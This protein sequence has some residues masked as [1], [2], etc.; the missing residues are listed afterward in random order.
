[1]DLQKLQEGEKTIRP[2]GLTS[3]LRI[4]KPT[5]NQ[6]QFSM[7]TDFRKAITAALLFLTIGLFTNGQAIFGTII[8]K[9][10]NKTIPNA[11]VY[12]N[13]TLIGT[14]SD[15]DGEFSLKLTGRISIPLTVS[16]LGYKTA[17]I[18][19]DNTNESLSIYLTPNPI[20]LG[21]V[22]VLSESLVKQRRINLDIF[23][24]IFLGTSENARNCIITNED[25]IT[26]NYNSQSDTLMAFASQP[27]R[28]E[29]RRLGYSLTYF[30]EC[31]E[32][33]RIT[34]AYLYKGNVM[35]NNDF[36]RKGIFRKGYVQVRKHT[37]HGSKM[38]F[39]RSLWFNKLDKER[40]EL[41]DTNF[42]TIVPTDF[43]KEYPLNNDTS[44]IAKCIQFPQSIIVQYNDKSY[45]YRETSKMQIV[46][47]IVYFDQDGYYDKTAI[48]WKGPMSFKH[49]G[50]MLPYE[51]QPKH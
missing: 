1:M 20:K 4:P 40:F 41:M 15:T 45:S 25:D 37:Y 39:F 46:K 48:E 27:L 38:H 22:T 51:Y 8:D 5:M 36:A 26:F 24:R 31:F 14:Q 6:N 44:S 17:T 3:I 33:N 43:V 50:D 42:N 12:F 30:L 18:A 2:N 16:C 19:A 9:S 11:C 32:Y 47:D 35:F 49:V 34:K 29:N 7:P 23:R 13:G 10:T 21:D 28:I